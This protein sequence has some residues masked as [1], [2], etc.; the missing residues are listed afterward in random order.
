[1]NHSRYNG[2]VRELQIFSVLPR[3]SGYARGFS[4]MDDG[5]DT[6]YDEKAEP[7][8]I[9]KDQRRKSNIERFMNSV[10]ASFENLSAVR[11][12]DSAAFIS[13]RRSSRCQPNY[14]G[15]GIFTATDGDVI[16]RSITRAGSKFYE[17]Q[18]GGSLPTGKL[19]FDGMKHLR[20]NPFV[21]NLSA[22][23]LAQC[24]NLDSLCITGDSIRDREFCFYDRLGNDL[25]GIYRS[26]LKTLSLSQLT[27]GADEIVEFLRRHMLT[28]VEVSL[29]KLA[30][31]T[32]SLFQLFS[33]LHEINPRP[34]VD[35]ADLVVQPRFHLFPAENG[36]HRELLDTFFH[37]DSPQDL[38]PAQSQLLTAESILKAS[39]PHLRPI[40]EKELKAYLYRRKHGSLLSVKALAQIRHLA[41]LI[42]SWERVAEDLYEYS[43]NFGDDDGDT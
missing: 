34:A 29:W 28:L 13:P 17:L 41:T 27:V 38:H 30:F 26:Q 22:R 19:S 10:F 35:A 1:M 31:L 9:T 32:G 12:G 37:M 5:L 42:K 18:L 3:L 25:C 2:M 23:L 16:F 8:L 11:F 43:E 33:D 36:L 40:L 15:N 4:F 7:F 24:P 39:H 21:G 20:L 6:F 14:F